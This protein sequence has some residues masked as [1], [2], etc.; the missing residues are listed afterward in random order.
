MRFTALVSILATAVAV[1]LLA[2][3]VLNSPAPEPGGGIEC[4]MVQGKLSCRNTPPGYR[5]GA[6]DDEPRLEQ[7]DED[8]CLEGRW[9]FGDFSDLCPQALW[10]ITSGTLVRD[11][12]PMGA[13]I[14][15]R[16]AV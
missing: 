8:F 9:Y 11:P 14:S 3:V 5:H 15:G 12:S 1:G 10:S 7:S 2:Y 6:A 16:R 13:F 4:K